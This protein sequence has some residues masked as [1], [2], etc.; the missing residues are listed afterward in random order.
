MIYTV[1]FNPAIDYIVQVGDMTLGAT[2]RT[3]Q[4]DLQFGG[5]GINV[6]AV[7]HNL[8]VANTALGFVAGY[9]GEAIEQR[10]QELGIS[11]DFIHLNNGTTRINVKI[12]GEGETAINGRG[13]DIPAEAVEQLMEKL[14]RICDGDTV[15][16]AGSVPVSTADD[17]YERILKRLLNK[18]VRTVVDAAGKL[19]ENVL[20]YR[21]FLIKPNLS[22]LGQ[23]FGLELEQTQEIISCAQKLQERGARNVLVSLGGEGALLLDEE[24]MVH[25]IG[26]PQGKLKSSVGAGDSMVAGFIAGYEQSQDYDFALRMGA[27]A[28]SATA[29][30][31]TLATR[32]EIETLLSVFS[33]QRE[34]NL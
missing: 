34:K 24:G 25:Q 6:S 11:T 33:R 17:I 1:T 27:A 20:K 9:T 13:P 4:E 19:M 14:D 2:N 31:P 3:Q 32:A 7:L 12:R 10:M 28:G 26:V 21:P 23:L 8:G 29:F 15:I 22:E 30:S 16:L 18:R 5:K